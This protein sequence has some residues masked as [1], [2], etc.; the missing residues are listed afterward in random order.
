LLVPRGFGMLVSVTVFGR[1]IARVV[2]RLLLAL[3][4]FLMR[5]KLPGCCR[6]LG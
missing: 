2:D 6:A 5:S 1:F 4:L 3:G